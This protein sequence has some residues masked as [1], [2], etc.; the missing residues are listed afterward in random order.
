[1]FFCCLLFQIIY[2]IYARVFARFAIVYADFKMQMCAR[3][4]F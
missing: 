4:R 3:I 1:V 2:G